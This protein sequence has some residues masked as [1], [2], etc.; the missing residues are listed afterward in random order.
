MIAPHTV[1]TVAT[2]GASCGAAWFRALRNTLCGF[3][4]A[5]TPITAITACTTACAPVSGCGH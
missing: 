4:A 1:I 5:N 2:A 3:A